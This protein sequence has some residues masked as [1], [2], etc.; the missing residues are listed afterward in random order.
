[1]CVLSRISDKLHLGVGVNGDHVVALGGLDARHGV[2][3]TV[4]TVLDEEVASL[5]EVD[6]AVVAHEALG[7]VELVPGLHDSADN[8]IAAAC[9]L[10]E[11]LESR[12]GAGDGAAQFGDWRP[13][14]RL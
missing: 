5:L 1:M 4:Q 2:G 13:D 11:L 9:A 7:V 8:A 14:W 10:G 6:A 12:H 3:L